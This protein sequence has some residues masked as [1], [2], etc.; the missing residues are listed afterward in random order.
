[1]AK[2]ETR[3]GSF[4]PDSNVNVMVLKNGKAIGHNCQYEITFETE[5]GILHVRE[6]F[7]TVMITDL[8]MSKRGDQAYLGWLTAGSYNSNIAEE[9]WIMGQ[10]GGPQ[11]RIEV[12]K[13]ELDEE[14][15][16]ALEV[17]KAVEGFGG[18]FYP[19]G[20]GE[21]YQKNREESV[22]FVNAHEDEI[23]AATDEIARFYAMKVPK[24]EI[25][26]AT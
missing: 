2:L 5:N 18:K 11:Y 15:V 24:T 23:I 19:Q 16:K 7:D 3:E 4:W 1:M 22:N 14:L 21:K 10:R 8:S 20:E 17:L 25:K 26:T 12:K 9:L 6:T 13:D